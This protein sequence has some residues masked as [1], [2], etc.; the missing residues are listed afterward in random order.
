MRISADQREDLR[1]VWVFL[2][3]DEAHEIREALESWAEEREGFTSPG[4]HM[5]VTD[6]DLELTLGIDP[7]DDDRSYAK[8]SD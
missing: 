7:G 1:D 3:P 6:G 2:T 5:H 4:W 8:R